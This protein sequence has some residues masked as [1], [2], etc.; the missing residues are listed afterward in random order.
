MM[1]V[2]LKSRYSGY[3]NSYVVILLRILM[4]AK[5][6]RLMISV[7]IDIFTMNSNMGIG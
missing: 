1:W 6:I 3:L 2:G 5:S 7:S 4:I